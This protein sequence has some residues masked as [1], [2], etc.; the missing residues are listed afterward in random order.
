MKKLLLTVVTLLRPLILRV[1]LVV[2]NI[3]LMQTNF[4]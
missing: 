1:T 2:T 4:D 3:S